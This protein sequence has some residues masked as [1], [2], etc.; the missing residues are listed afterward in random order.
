MFHQ[1]D[2]VQAQKVWNTNVEPQMLNFD[3]A[4]QYDIFFNMLPMLKIIVMR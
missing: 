3:I 2:V 1:A 4:S